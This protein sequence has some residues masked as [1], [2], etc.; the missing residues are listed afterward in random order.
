M[1]NEYIKDVL[2]WVAVTY[3]S[4]RFI[5]ILGIVNSFFA[6]LFPQ[7][8]VSSLMIACVSGAYLVEHYLIHLLNKYN[9]DLDEAL[10]KLER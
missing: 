9:F 2:T 5:Y 6:L 3:L 8:M 4:I 10:D 7:I 1:S